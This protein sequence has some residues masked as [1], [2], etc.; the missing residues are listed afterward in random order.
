MELTGKLENLKK[1]ELE[2]HS[3]RDAIVQLKSKLNDLNPLNPSPSF[4]CNLTSVYSDLREAGT[5]LTNL[6]GYLN[7][8]VLEI[9]D[10]DANPLVLHLRKSISSCIPSEFDFRLN[11]QEFDEP[12]CERDYGALYVQG[13]K[14]LYGLSTNSL[15]QYILFTRWLCER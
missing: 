3:H 6:R 8:E 9:P 11:H 14:F 7:P 13:L 15:F 2:F 5:I 12:P 1:H 10:V 4:L